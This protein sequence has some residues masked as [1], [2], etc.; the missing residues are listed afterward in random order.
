MCSFPQQSNLMKSD[1]DGA[2]KAA[3][4][5]LAEIEERKKQSVASKKLLAE[6]TKNFMKLNPE[7]APGAFS[8]LLK[9]YQIEVEAL[10]RRS[11]LGESS[12]SQLLSVACQNGNKPHS[13][14]EAELEKLRTDF[15]DMEAELLKMKNQ[16]LTVRRLEMKLREI[17]KQHKSDLSNMESELSR[18]KDEA[19]ATYRAQLDR[20]QAEVLSLQRKNENLNQQISELNKTVYNH[21]SKSDVALQLK[22]QEIN[23]LMEELEYTRERITLSTGSTSK[24]GTSL[25]IYRDLV[26]QAEERNVELEKLI[27]ELS[28]SSE[29][30]RNKAFTESHELQGQIAQMQVELH[31]RERTLGEIQTHLFKLAEEHGY[32]TNDATECLQR[33]NENI[34]Q[35]QMERDSLKA[36]VTELSAQRS[37]LESRLKDT[38]REVVDVQIPLVQTQ[39][40]HSM[41]SIVQAQRDRLRARVDELES[42]RDTLKQAKLD[43]NNKLNMISSEKQRLEN[44]RNFWKG[45]SRE[46]RAEADVESGTYN[47]QENPPTLS[48][49]IVRSFP[50]SGI[51]QSVTSL[52]IWGLGNSVTRR[53]VLAYVLTLH[54]LVFMVLYRL[55]SFVGSGNRID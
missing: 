2:V 10:S 5:Q 14:N 30:L 39:N 9:A 55:S 37:G 44:E 26:D 48:T 1:L 3:H 46:S 42:E 7:D 53:A 22:Q 34:N 18:K 52:V 36:S 15:K 29:A 20:F 33:L 13:R 23:H 38:L 21:K 25:D 40:A 19:E 31:D 50:R 4:S 16:D 47:G 41:I 24:M 17:E 11:K 28:D 49:R 45:Q 8:D 12:F 35:I 32:P 27:K 6:K 43:F 51:E 54:I